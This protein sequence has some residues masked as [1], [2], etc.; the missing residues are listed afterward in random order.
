MKVDQ[1]HSEYI[2]ADGLYNQ[3]VRGTLS[4]MAALQS[5]DFLIAENEQGFWTFRQFLTKEP[6]ADEY[7]GVELLYGRNC[8]TQALDEVS[9]REALQEGRDQDMK[10]S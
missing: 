10:A 6:M 2:Q 3:V 5:L 4:K 7:E 1:S 9:I 8:F